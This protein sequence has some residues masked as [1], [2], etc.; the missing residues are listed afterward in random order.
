MP[1]SSSKTGP[2]P[3]IE[4]VLIY[5]LGSLGDTVVALPSYH[6]IARAFPNAERRLLT[7][8]PVHGKAPAAAAVLGESGLVHGYIHYPVGLRGLRRI[9]GLWSE[10]R[11]FRP[12]VLVY[13]A[14][15]RGPRAVARDRR[16]FRLCGLRETIGFPHSVED[17]ERRRLPGRDQWQPEAARLAHSIRELGDANLDDPSSW[18]LRLTPAEL[19]RAAQV[20]REFNGTRFLVASLG[21]KAQAND[22]GEANWTALLGRLAAL[23]P[24]HRLALIGAP[25]EREICNRAANAWNNRAMNLC[26]ALAPRESAALLRSADLFLGHDSGPMHLASAVGTPCV[27]VFSARNP[28]GVWFPYGQRNRVVY[29]RT[30]CAGCGLTTCIEEKKKCILSITVDEV[31]AAALESLEANASPTS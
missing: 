1:Q 11:R 26:G 31:L 13:L 30:D 19:T 14:A 9:L 15:L 8:I 27:A 24:H 29:H 28:P 7:N 17:F 12:Q 4:R 5:R 6:Q 20:Q 22:W 25:D 3:E 10:I 16:F 21:T 2:R 23:L 18:D